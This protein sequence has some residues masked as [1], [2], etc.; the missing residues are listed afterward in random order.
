MGDMRACAASPR[1]HF[2]SFSNELLEYE[3]FGSQNEVSRHPEM[4]D[5]QN[6]NLTYS[7]LRLLR[8]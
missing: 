7:L 8:T 1:S 3:Y 4:T 6:V 2:P 5:L